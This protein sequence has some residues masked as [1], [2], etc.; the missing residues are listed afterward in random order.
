MSA[1]AWDATVYMVFASRGDL[2][3][4]LLSPQHDE[5]KRL[6]VPMRSEGTL[7]DFVVTQ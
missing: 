6:I 5:I 4:Y 7:I 3:A 1:D 2:Q